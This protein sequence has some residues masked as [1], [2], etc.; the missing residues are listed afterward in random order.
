MNRWISYRNSH[1]CGISKHLAVM[2]SKCWWVSKSQQLIF[3]HS[4]GGSAMSW[5]CVYVF[6]W[7][8]QCVYMYVCQS[9]TTLSF[10]KT[11]KYPTTT[12]PSRNQQSENHSSPPKILWLLFPSLFSPWPRSLCRCLLRCLH[13]QS[14]ITGVSLLQKQLL[15]HKYYKLSGRSSL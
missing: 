4:V 14:D 12:F 5:I 2:T 10:F 7:T 11:K 8:P 13:L 3:L 15:L 9:V 1:F 6:V